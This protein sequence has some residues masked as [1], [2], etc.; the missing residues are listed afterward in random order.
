[1]NGIFNSF[2]VLGSVWLFVSLFSIPASSDSYNNMFL[3]TMS[4][5]PCYCWLEHPL[6]SI[7][8]G[9]QDSA[10]LYIQQII[11]YRI[12][13]SIRS[14]TH[15][16]TDLESEAFEVIG[17][18][19]TAFP[20]QHFNPFSN[21]II[22][23]MDHLTMIPL[24]SS[25]DFDFGFDTNFDPNFNLGIN[26]QIE[27]YDMNIDIQLSPNLDPHTDD[28]AAWQHDSNRDIPVTHLN[29]STED[30]MALS[31]IVT[32]ESTI[33][34]CD[35]PSLSRPDSPTLPG[36]ESFYGG[37]GSWVYARGLRDNIQTNN[38]RTPLPVENR[39]N[40]SRDYGNVALET[41]FGSHAPTADEITW[42]RE[43]EYRL[44]MTRSPPRRPIFDNANAKMYSE[45]RNLSS[46][47]LHSFLGVGIEGDSG[48][49]AEE[50]RVTMCGCG[51]FA[52]AM[53]AGVAGMFRGR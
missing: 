46:K 48:S 32:D 15:S 53:K 52:G 1:M 16:T 31:Q 17:L 20:L 30:V 37:R 35:S 13:I 43:L 5:L 47:N 38:P 26:S 34:G 22:E 4:L 50:E 41:T 21:P 11:P 6:S 42:T 9:I 18:I 29:V 39:G 7:H 24:A 27:D 12:I 28:L 49:D 3:N 2:S 36:R 44:R 33:I 23:G 8:I 45:D 10:H 51:I 19:S 14:L 40:K 25:N